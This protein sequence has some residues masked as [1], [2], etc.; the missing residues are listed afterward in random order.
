MGILTNIPYVHNHNQ[1]DI[2]I[3]QGSTHDINQMRSYQCRSQFKIY[4]GS[5]QEFRFNNWLCF[6]ITRI[7]INIYI[8]SRSMIQ[9]IL[10]NQIFII[11]FMHMENYPLTWLER[12]FG[13]VLRSEM[14]WF[15]A[16]K[17]TL[18]CLQSVVEEL[19]WGVL[20]WSNRAL[21]LLNFKRRW[22]RLENSL[23]ESFLAWRERERVLKKICIPW[24]PLGDLMLW[25][26]P[27]IC[28]QSVVKE[29]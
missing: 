10:T 28:L 19:L 23:R 1:T 7:I 13:R 21:F 25:R 12:E 20:A 22:R 27:L 26:V 14:L 17:S 18:I 11:F 9:F 4:T 15:D 16:L 3:S 24:N 2:F 5:Y 29:L 6:I 8:L